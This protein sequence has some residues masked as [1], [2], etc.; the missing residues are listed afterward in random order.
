[1]W[2][3]LGPLIVT[4]VAAFLRLWNL[5]RPTTL[6]FDETYYVKYAYSLMRGGYE[7]SW[8]TDANGPFAHGNPDTYLR[9]ADYVVHPPLGKWMISLGMDAFGGAENPWSWRISSAVFGTIAVFLIARI[10]RRLFASTAMGVIAGALL[11]VDGEAIVHSRTGLLDGFLMFWVLV[12]FGCFVLDRDQARMRLATRCAARLDSGLPLGNFGP[13]L[14]WRWWRFAGAISLG[15][16]CGIKWSGLYFVAV[17]ALLSVLWDFS[18]RRAVGIRRWFEDAFVADGLIAALV[19]LPTVALTYLATWTGW[20]TSK[21]S[22]MRHWAQENPG[23]GW[24]ILPPAWRS[25]VQYHLNMWEFHNGLDAKH[26][27]QA[28]P[29]GWI[30]R[31]RPT[32][33][34][35]D[36]TSRGQGGCEINNCVRAITSIGNPAIW[37]CGALAILVTLW[38]LFT[39]RDWRA[40][41]VLSGL[42]AGWVPWFFYAHRTIF[43][44]YSIAFLPWVI[45]TL[46]YVMT[47][48]LERTER[49]LAARNRVRLV[50][51]ALLTVIGVLSIFWYPIWT[52]MRVPYDFWHIH[53]WL[54]SWI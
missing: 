43:T 34:Y 29:L 13:S 23:E 21:H 22:Y 51:I 2:G 33:F 37:W 16:A 19:V 5:G 40:L 27:Y 28:H 14:G 6:V 38:L 41:A 46:V 31:W 48:A 52:A 11:A 3:W 35:W 44:F 15:L 8:P 49:H 25:F 26:D 17:F 24:T 10:A 42:L 9:T 39:K 32:S 50:I 12:A 20:F 45:L 18:A 36:S 53:M 1:M 7:A 54:P 4:A 30:V 47:Y